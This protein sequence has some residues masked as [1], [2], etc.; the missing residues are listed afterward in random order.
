MQVTKGDLPAHTG[1]RAF[2]ERLLP[3]PKTSRKEKKPMNLEIKVQRIQKMEN[4]N[5]LKA[6]ADITVNDSILIKSLRVVEG[7][8]GLF[9]SMPQQQAKD[10]KW[11]ES[12]KCLNSDV[13]E[14][15]SD[16]ILYAYQHE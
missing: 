4:G 10:D 1:G 9:V 3:L 7:K 2:G 13:K 6:Y 14:Y 8:N 11:Y 15:I 5:S 16:T 12:V